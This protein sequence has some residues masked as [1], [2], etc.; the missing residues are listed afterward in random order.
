MLL[1]YWLLL[2][3]ICHTNADAI[4]WSIS[5]LTM[6]D[7]YDKYVHC[8]G[9]GFKNFGNLNSDCIVACFG[10]QW[11][12]VKYEID[13]REVVDWDPEQTSYS[14]FTGRDYIPTWPG[15]EACTIPSTITLWP[16]NTAM[17]ISLTLGCTWMILMWVVRSGQ[18]LK[19]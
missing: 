6:N 1:L 17:G 7:P 19:R 14:I 16:P 3:P 9:I 11:G 2:A 10:P 12:D 5:F 13:V 8:C 4:D 15:V 18:G